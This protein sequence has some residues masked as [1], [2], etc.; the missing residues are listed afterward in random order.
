LKLGLFNRLLNT[1]VSESCREFL[2]KKVASV[3][4]G[5]LRKLNL[6]YLTGVARPIW[7]GIGVRP[8]AAGNARG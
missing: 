8:L 5:H 6:I 4:E 7:A 2:T 1:P 3:A